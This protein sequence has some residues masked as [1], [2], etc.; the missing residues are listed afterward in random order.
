MCCLIFPHH[1]L[2]FPK[3]RDPLCVKTDLHVPRRTISRSTQHVTA[4]AR[5]E[6]R[7]LLWI[8][9]LREDPFSNHSFCSTPPPPPISLSFQTQVM[10]KWIEPKI[11]LEGVTGAEPLPPSGDREPC[12]PCNPGFYNNDTATCSPC[13]PGT[14]SD[15][16]KRTENSDLYCIPYSYFSLFLLCVG[17]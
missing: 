10:Y 15:G 9:T 11:C 3:L 14:Y 2:S 7:G 17:S 1:N 6:K 13:P 16:M 4:R 8:K 12:P 5:W